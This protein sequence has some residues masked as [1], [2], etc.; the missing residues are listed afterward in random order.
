MFISK[1]QFRILKGKLQYCKWRL[2]SRNSRIQGAGLYDVDKIYWIGTERV[3]LSLDSPARDRL[4]EKEIRSSST[5]TPL[6]ERG[7]IVGGDWD[8]RT[9]CFEEQDVWSAFKHHFEEGKDWG[10]TDFYDRV[11]RTI[12]GGVSMWSCKTREAFDIRLQGIDKLYQE[13]KNNGY[14]TQDTIDSGGYKPLGNEDEIQVHIGRDGEYIFADGRHRFCVAKLLGLAKIPVKVARRHTDWVAFRQEIISYADKQPTGKLYSRLLH[15]DLEDIPS[16]HEGD[17]RFEL[18]RK[19][20]PVPSGTVLDIGAHWGYFCHRLE[21][22]GFD[23]VA[24]EY[25]PI[26]QYFIKKIRDVEKLKF[27]IMMGS[28]LKHE[29]NLHY[30]IALALNIFHHFIKNKDEYERLKRF[31]NRLDVNNMFFES[32]SPNES[33]MKKQGIYKNFQADEFAMWVQGHAGFQEIKFL[34]GTTEGRR[35]YLLSRSPHSS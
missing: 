5:L 6:L 2:Q 35:M 13:I 10:K 15:P 1:E 27:K 4:N 20:L 18:I 7:K 32:H 16:V 23:C 19:N 33:Q 21:K 30:D 24:S 14:R 22:L 17:D 29:E 34:G 28:I 3:N 26:N 11:V 25:L 12:E 8:R 9:I 31:L